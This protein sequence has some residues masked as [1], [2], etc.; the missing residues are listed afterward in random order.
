MPGDFRSDAVHLRPGE[1]FDPAADGAGTLPRS[2]ARSLRARSGRP[3]L[4]DATG[5]TL[6]YA[7]L[8]AA[9]ARV[10]GRL[11]AAGVA[12]G[13]RVLFS[14]AA[15]LELA[16]AH[17]ACLRLGGVALPANTAYREPELAHLVGDARAELVG[18][19]LAVDA[20]GVGHVVSSCVAVGVRRLGA[21]G[22]ARAR[23]AA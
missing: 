12:P 19:R 4:L 20:D 10:A 13:D 15:S 2:W 23:R 17:V 18:K 16:V 5:R 14:A 8:D 11:S 22:R 7:E 21:V 1:R 9:S 3:A 6:T